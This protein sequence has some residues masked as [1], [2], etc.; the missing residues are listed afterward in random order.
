MECPIAV[1]E[2]IGFRF[3]GGDRP[4][5]RFDP[6]QVSER[7]KAIINPA[8]Y[9]NN[10]VPLIV[11]LCALITPS[12]SSGISAIKSITRDEFDYLALLEKQKGYHLSIEEIEKELL[13]LRNYIGGK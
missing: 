10:V 5:Y 7:N 9:S 12:A 2:A 13:K 1:I 8:R 3:F 6:G 4:R 11:N